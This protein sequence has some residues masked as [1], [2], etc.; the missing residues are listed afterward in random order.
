MQNLWAVLMHEVLQIGQLGPMDHGLR[1]SVT[2]GTALVLLA[3]VGLTMHR[4]LSSAE[5]VQL[6]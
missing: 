2:S 4:Q 1:R 5:C 6:V 3:H